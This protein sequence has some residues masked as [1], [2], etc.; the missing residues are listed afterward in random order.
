MATALLAGAAL[1]FAPP[2]YSQKQVAAIDFQ[3]PDLSRLSGRKRSSTIRQL[4]LTIRA[5]PANPDAV[6]V[7]L[8]TEL[9]EAASDDA[10]S[11]D[12]L[13]EVTTTLSEALRECPMRRDG[14]YLELASLVRYERMRAS[15]D[16]PRMAAAMAKLE[17]EGRD[18][19]QADFTL[20][21]LQGKSW[22]LKDLRGKV[23]LVNF[24]GA[25]CSPC[26]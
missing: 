8:A 20:A 7:V 16:D 5:M 19:R 17:G 21:D 10:S 6:K 23:V 24:C 13:Q 4:A 11:R 1:S 3:M 2:L 25:W 9:A 12:T 14:P 18:I 15:L 26:V 22:T